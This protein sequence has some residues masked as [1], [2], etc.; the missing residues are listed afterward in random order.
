MGKNMQ[1]HQIP[2]TNAPFQ[3]QTIEFLNRKIRIT[4]RFNSIGNSWVMDVFEQIN[5]K[6]ICQG[7]ALVCG[8]KL[9]ERTTQPYFLWLSDESGANLDP[10]SLNDLGSRCFLYIGEKI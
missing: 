8:V 9:L 2:I 10:M 6:Q 7:L 1:L 4:L 5:Q 3:E